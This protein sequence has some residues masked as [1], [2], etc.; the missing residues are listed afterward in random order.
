MVIN[1]DDTISIT[2]KDVTGQRRVSYEIPR[3]AS[4][5]DVI[6]RLS[7]RMNLFREDATGRPI[8]WFARHEREGRSLHR[9]EVARDIFKDRDEI[10]LQPEISAGFHA[11]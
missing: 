5:E 6:E 7:T 2:A 11:D 10:R 9:S 4:V 3:D 8:T 1:Q